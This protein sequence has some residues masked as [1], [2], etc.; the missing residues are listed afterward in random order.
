MAGALPVAQQNDIEARNLRQQKLNNQLH[1]HG[2]VKPAVKHKYEV[3]QSPAILC[4]VDTNNLKGTSYCVNLVLDVITL[5]D[6]QPILDGI[7][8]TSRNSSASDEAFT[9]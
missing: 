9:G 3:Q 6:M 5:T 8:F 4:K 2:A 7:I 1:T